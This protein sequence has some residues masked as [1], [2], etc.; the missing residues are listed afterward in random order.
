MIPTSRFSATV[1]RNPK[2]SARDNAIGWMMIPSLTG[3]V[4]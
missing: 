2:T 4:W 1:I 3:P